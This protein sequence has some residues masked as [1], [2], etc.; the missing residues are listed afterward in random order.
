MCEA[1]QAFDPM[2]NDNETATPILN[3]FFI[4]DTHHNTGS[5]INNIKREFLKE[6][7][8]ESLQGTYLSEGYKFSH[9]CVP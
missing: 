4:T 9:Q 3:N 6:K 7:F 8:E 2:E 1:H 5:I